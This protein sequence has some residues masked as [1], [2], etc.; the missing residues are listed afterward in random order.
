MSDGK[1]SVYIKKQNSLNPTWSVGFVI[2]LAVGH[3]ALS[4]FAKVTNTKEKILSDPKHEED[5]VNVY[6]VI[7]PGL[8]RLLPSTSALI[9][10]YLVCTPN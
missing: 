4:M 6:F 3:S 9:C 8:P 7:L 2:G 10:E 1:G 5:R